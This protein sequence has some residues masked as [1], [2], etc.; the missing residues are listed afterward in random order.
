MGGGKSSREEGYFF[1]VSSVQFPV[2]LLEDDLLEIG[3]SVSQ[4][5]T[6]IKRKTRILGLSFCFR[7]FLY[8]TMSVPHWPFA[9]CPGF[10]Q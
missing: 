7:L 9:R 10:E 1:S 5:W 4:M 6:G 3:G 2:E 8:S